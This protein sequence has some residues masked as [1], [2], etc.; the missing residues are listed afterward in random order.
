MCLRNPI[1]GVPSDFGG[2]IG[3]AR[4]TVEDT[5]G[6][7]VCGELILL[8]P[9]VGGSVCSD[10]LRTKAAGAVFA[11]G[12]GTVS[13]STDSFAVSVT[14]NCVKSNCVRA[15]ARTISSASSSESVLSV[16][17]NE[18][19]R[20]KDD[21]CGV[22]KPPAGDGRGVF[23]SKLSFGL[24]DIAGLAGDFAGLFTTF[25]ARGG[26]DGVCGVGLTG[27]LGG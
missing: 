8:A 1:G 18:A 25:A 9:A 3:A 2:V 22:D 13:R 23:T 20:A 19:A 17:L 4:V 6:I 11:G 7:D 26:F 15:A 21:D 5:T 16:V 27:V 14:S 24:A 12:S 10:I